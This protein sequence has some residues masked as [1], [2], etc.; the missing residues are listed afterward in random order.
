[1]M[2]NCSNTV[3]LTLTTSEWSVVFAASTLATLIHNIR[4]FVSDSGKHTILAGNSD[5]D[6]T[7]VNEWRG[8]ATLSLDTVYMYCVQTLTVNIGK[9]S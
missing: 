7:L 3:N 2:L 8:A 1:M 5:Q 4:C 9:N 6:N